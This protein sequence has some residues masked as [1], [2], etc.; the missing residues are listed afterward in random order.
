MARLKVWPMRK[1]R[2]HIKSVV[3]GLKCCSDVGSKSFKTNYNRGSSGSSNNVNN[4]NTFKGSSS[5]GNRS[6][7]LCEYCKR[8]GHTKDRCYKLHCYPSNTKSPRGKGLGSVVNVYASEDNRSQC[9]ETPEKGR[10]IPLNMSKSGVVNLAD[11][12]A[13]HHMTYT[14]DALTNLSNIA[15]SFLI[16]LPNGYKGPSLKSPLALCKAK[17]VR[18]LLLEVNAKF[19]PKM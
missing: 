2:P 6:N 14:K 7:L 19:H 12:G 17:N 5:T 8:T 13:S 4:T 3:S 9:K 1:Q 11:S 16:T 15:L 18:K 10:Q